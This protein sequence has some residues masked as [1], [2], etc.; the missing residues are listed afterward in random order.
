MSNRKG[1]LYINFKYCKKLE[2]LIK[3]PKKPS[4]AIRFT[5]LLMK[6][7]PRSERNL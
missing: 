6:F 5:N 7:L 1:T 2:R 4:T 3:A